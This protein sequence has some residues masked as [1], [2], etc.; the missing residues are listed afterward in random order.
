MPR[1]SDEWPLFARDVPDAAWRPT[2][3]DQAESRLARFLRASGDPDLTTLQRH[4]AA[5]PAWFWGAAADDIGLR[6]Q[7]RPREVLDLSRGVEWARWWTGGA[8]NYA[9]AAVDPRAD[10][11]PGGPAVAWEGED[12]EI[13]RL[14]NAELKAQ[15]DRAAGMLASLG[16][17][18]GDRVGI[19]L[20]LLPETVIAVLALG[21]MG[22]IYTPIFSGYAGPAAAS[23]FADCGAKLLITAD[24][25]LRRGA[26]VR[27][28]RTADEAVA[29]APTVERVLVVRR[30]GDALDPVP[31][32]EGRDIWWDDAMADPSIR[33]LER[34]P[35]LDPETPYMVIYTSGT[36]GRP[37]GAVHVHGG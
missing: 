32:T 8:F 30:L 12:G 2:A 13:R 36:T 1:M 37:K 28:K 5:D 34:A 11:P 24:G 31:W 7:R 25:F 35:E 10:A 6:W 14:T 3:S 9:A 23:R 18:P 17:N 26:V 27:L 4:A 21:R 20:P 16:V 15:V 22:A 33:P 29:G 19:F